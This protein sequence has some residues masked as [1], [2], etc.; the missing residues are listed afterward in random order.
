MK[1]KIRKSTVYTS[2]LKIAPLNS[3]PLYESLSQI[4]R[5]RICTDYEESFQRNNK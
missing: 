3:F 5:V 1:K 4:D 2:L